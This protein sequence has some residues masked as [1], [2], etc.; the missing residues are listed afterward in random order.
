MLAVP[1]A[2]ATPHPTEL[3]FLDPGLFVPEIPHEAYRVLRDE[4]PVSWHQPADASKPGYWLLVRHRDV[5][6]ASVDAAAFSSWRGTTSMDEVPP[7]RLDISRMM[8]LNM[9]PPGHTRY[10]KLLSR[11]FASRAI[12]RLEP[13]VREMCRAILREVAGRGACDFVHDVAAKLPMQVIAEMVGVAPQH[14]ERLYQISNALIGFDDPDYSGGREASIASAMEMYGYAAELA[15]ERRAAP[16]DDLASV[17]LAAEVD[18]ER[19]SDAE[20]NAFFLLLVVAGNETTRNL[21]AGGLA[22]LFAH[23]DQRALLEADVGRRL[24]GAV[25]EMLRVVS[26]VTQ[27]RRTASR[28][29]TLH[30][31]T[32]REGDKVILAHVSANHDERTFADP[33][34]FDITRAPNPHVAF[35][36]GPHL[37]MGAALARLEARVMFEELFATLPDIAPAGPAARMRSNFVNGY[38]SMPVRFAPREV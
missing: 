17:L 32:I 1:M 20:F 29:V 16:R 30:G 2:N 11:G 8:L 15:A 35:G 25:E 38:K 27:F 18:G 5:F 19:L 14:R 21:I 6:D 13:R 26:P 12:E 23:P 34:R 9:D 22:A 31:Q 24:P 4:A 36:A 10:R 37:C 33:R 7:E 3:D 28:D